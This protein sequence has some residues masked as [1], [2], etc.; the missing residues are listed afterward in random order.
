MTVL[1]TIGPPVA[2]AIAI[3]ALAG[4]YVRR[5]IHLGDAK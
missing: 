4:V 5:L 2:L 3:T 1:M